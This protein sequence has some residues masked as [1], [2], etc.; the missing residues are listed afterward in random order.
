MEKDIQHYLKN[1]K[2]DINYIN[3][4]NVNTDSILIIKH[5]KCEDKQEN[6]ES[7]TPVIIGNRMFIYNYYYYY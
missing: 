1:E 2:R 4:N 5:Q 6:Q 3:D 7:T